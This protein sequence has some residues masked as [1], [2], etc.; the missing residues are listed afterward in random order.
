MGEKSAEI[1]HLESTTIRSLELLIE[2]IKPGAIC[3]E[4][5]KIN[6]DN[7]ARHGYTLGH[8]SGYSTGV[9]YAPDWGEG[10]ILSIRPDEKREIQK[11]MVFH[12]VPG[13]YVEG[14]HV[15]VIS[16]TVVVTENGCEPLTTY[17]RQVFV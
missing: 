12:L 14:K 16:E 13:I 2:N 10:N 4:V 9:N 5:H 8:R 15:V 17:P 7:F 1:K 11:G 3:E 6:A